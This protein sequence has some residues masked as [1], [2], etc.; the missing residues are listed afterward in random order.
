MQEQSDLRGILQDIQARLARL[1]EKLDNQN[2]DQFD[3]GAFAFNLRRARDKLFPAE[4]FSDHGWDILLEL[5]QAQQS[6]RKIQTSALG[7]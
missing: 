6:G 7:L 4:Y 1:E 2:S 5:F 3:I